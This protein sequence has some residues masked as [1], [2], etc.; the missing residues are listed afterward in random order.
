M[1]CNVFT[2]RY[3]YIHTLAGVVVNHLAFANFSLAN[4]SA[5]YNQKEA[6]KGI[7][8]T[9]TIFPMYFIGNSFI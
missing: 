9:S 7:Q 6:R 4:I 3:G 5:S 1:K 2:Y 8:C